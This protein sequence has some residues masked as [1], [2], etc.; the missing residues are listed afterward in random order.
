MDTY[1]TL[2]G[3]PFLLIDIIAFSWFVL[4]IFGYRLY[5]EGFIRNPKPSIISVMNQQRLEWMHQMLE[6]DN[7]IVDATI[8]GNLLRSI[9]F[10]AS[11]SILIIAGLITALGYRDKGIDIIASLPFAAP[12]T[13]LMWEVKMLLLIMI[14]TYAFFKYT[15]SLRTHNYS[16]ILI[17]A[18]PPITASKKVKEKFAQKGAALAVNAARHFNRGLRAYYFGL[19]ALSWFIHPLLFMLSMTLV[20]AIIWRREF[21]ST[22]LASL[23]GETVEEQHS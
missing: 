9:A 19:A 8:V 6:R 2:A 4:C 1:I 22:A 17:G 16:S 21:R 12:T 7:R 14:F 23:L 3:T 13:P 5:T 18:A 10:F 20:T 11:T 15:W